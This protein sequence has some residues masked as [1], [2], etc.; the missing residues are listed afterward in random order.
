VD[1]KSGYRFVYKAG[2][3]WQVR[4]KHRDQCIYVGVFDDKDDAARAADFVVHEQGWP[5]N[6][7]NFPN[8]QQR[9]RK[10]DPVAR[11]RINDNP[12][13]T[14]N[15][16][17]KKGVHLVNNTGQGTN[18]EAKYYVQVFKDN[19]TY[20]LPEKFTNINT[21]ADAFDKMAV[22]LG[23]SA[24]YLNSPQNYDRHVKDRDNELNLLV[25]S[26]LK[27]KGAHDIVAELQTDFN[28]N[29]EQKE[30]PMAGALVEKVSKGRVSRTYK[31]RSKKKTHTTTNNTSSGA[32]IPQP[33]ALPSTNP[34]TSLQHHHHH[35][36]QYQ[37]NYQQQQNHQLHMP[38][39]YHQQVYQ[40][41]APKRTGQ[42]EV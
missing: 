35:Q 27:E 34:S 2:K 41:V 5:K 10:P 25:L 1:L 19:V 16:T 28:F 39:Q 12:Q 7:L 22:A 31:E 15:K 30:I 23:R 3:R 14:K 37:H 24:N 32:S 26:Y 8:E 42:A 29:I 38:Y 13:G 4:C 9:S 18:K 17:G 33:V 11:G 20:T 6:K 21:A 40:G 36:Q